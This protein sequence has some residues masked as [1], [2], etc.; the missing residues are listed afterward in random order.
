MQIT[1]MG[2]QVDID[3]VHLDIRQQQQYAGAVDNWFGF[4]APELCCY[5]NDYYWP[6][7]VL[8]EKM[9]TL[10]SPTAVSSNAEQLLV[11]KR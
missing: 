3:P 9:I 2:E 11:G 8:D 1:A 4:F 6:R 10:A 7:G 5:F